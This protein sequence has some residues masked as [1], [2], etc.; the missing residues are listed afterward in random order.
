MTNNSN[1]DTYS[2]PPKKGMG[3]W[4]KVFVGCAAAVLLLLGSCVGLAYWATHSGK[5]YVSAKM[6]GLMEV[7][8]S[9][10]VEV[11]EAIKTDEGTLKLYEEN[12]RLTESYP[13]KD[14]FLEQA[15][16]WRS[17]FS[18]L[19]TDPPIDIDLLGSSKIGFIKR[20][21]NKTTFLSIRYQ[22]PSKAYITLDWENDEL[23][24]IDLR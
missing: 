5:E 10:M 23:V 1:W 7:P 4:A 19:P 22:L 17:A 6:A 11:A 13:S 21:E 14:A 9:K 15:R 20:Q 3:V 12:P 24:G 16:V 8:W 18:G 2:E